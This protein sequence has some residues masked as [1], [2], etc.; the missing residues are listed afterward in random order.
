MVNFRD[1]FLFLSGGLAYPK[2]CQKSVAMYDIA[3][4]I[5]THVP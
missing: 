5:W 3:G 4:D 2:E 1:E